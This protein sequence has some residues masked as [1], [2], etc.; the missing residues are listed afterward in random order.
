MKLPIPSCKYL[1]FNTGFRKAVLRL[2][3]AVAAFA[4][5]TSSACSTLSSSSAIEDGSHQKTEFNLWHGWRTEKQQI[6]ESIVDEFNCRN[7]DIRILAESPASSG[8]FVAEQMLISGARRPPDLALVDRYSI[9]QLAKAGLIRPL[10]EF[11]VSRTEPG[12]LLREQELLD[13]AQAY[14]GY[15]GKLYGVPAYLNPYVLIYN[16]EALRADTGTERPP[17]SW[18]DLVNIGAKLEKR[19][20]GEERWVLSVRSMAPM[21]HI[22]C[23]QKGINLFEAEPGGDAIESV[24]ERLDFIRSLRHEH[25]L[26]PPHYKYWDPKFAGVAD[27]RALF[28]IDTATMFA[29]IK[30]NSEW[31]LEVSEVPSDSHTSRTALARSP[32]FVVSS[33]ADTTA[34]MKFLE[35]FYSPEQYSRFIRESMVVSPW[36]DAISPSNKLVSDSRSYSQIV[37]AAE[38]ASVLPLHSRTGKVMP[39]IAQIVDKLDA[40]LMS[41]RKAKKE[42]LKAIGE[43]R[44]LEKSSSASIVVS[45]ADSTARLLASDRAGSRS[46][47][48]WISAG[49]NE[50]E[51]FQLALSADIERKGLTL[52][53]APF[54]SSDNDPTD[55][56]F[57]A[58]L[59]EDTRVSKPLVTAKAGFYPNVLRPFDEFGISPGKLTRIWISAFVAAS[60]S[61]GEY[62]SRITITRGDTVE[63][64]IPIMLRV[65]PLK[66]PETPAQPAFIG[67][68]YDLIAGHY[69]IDSEA[70]EHRALMDAFYWYLVERRLTPLQPPV[71]LDSPHLASYMND[72]RVSG[73]RIP[74]NP[75]EKRFETAAAFAEQG[76]W[77]DRTF[78]YFIDEPTYHQYRKVLDAAERIHSMP[79]SPKFLVACFPD[80]PL[81]GA[82]DIWCIHLRFLPEGIP[83]GHMERS[84]Y[85]EAVAA[86]L[87]AGDDVWWY[88][89]GAVAPVPTLH[90]EDDPAAFRIIPWMQQ[91]YQITGFL[92]WEAAN[93]Q[94]SLDDPFVDYFGNGEGVLVYPGKAGPI[95]SIRLELLREGLED[96]E[97]LTLLRSG[98]EQVRRKLA[99]E[100]YEDAAAIRV[101]E[102]CRRLIQEAALRASESGDVLLLS[103]FSREPGLIE[104][105]R[106]EVAEETISLDR[107]PYAIVL[108]EPEEKRYTGFDKARIYGLIEPGSRVEINGC[109][110]IVAESGEF[111]A[112]FPLHSGANNFEILLRNGE[113]TKLI[114]RRIERF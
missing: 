83:R 85:V 41:P 28:Q 98:V 62:S 67:L 110:A 1:L 50:N 65:F 54:I 51:S 44:T 71:P 87:E 48:V 34:A 70:D 32:V 58:A 24:E 112:H 104:R 38:H 86:R 81:I 61:P 3:F 8:G 37:S 53:C 39:E 47:P 103:H 89:A 9:P 21:F 59:I 19:P 6:L 108:T 106:G 36:K 68:N 42:M 90:V 60:V 45:W 107:R 35:F 84:K 13:A 91:L 40:G 102:I 29:R 73:C 63:A 43:G 4:L 15:E 22:L 100:E 26:L 17:A 16:P 20:A 12:K 52:S 96:L 27:G 66:I 30:G 11:F 79:S 10:D 82:V 74:F 55:I 105:V 97:Y 31:K 69:K 114:H 95:S 49:R 78:S 5:V 113:N 101:G 46:P 93:W 14:G 111:S 64:E 80:N 72:E 94:G 92:H 76:G 7:S 77:L 88:T 2:S 99:T 109:E 75:A 56:K 57:D 33:T 18:G 23:A 25:L